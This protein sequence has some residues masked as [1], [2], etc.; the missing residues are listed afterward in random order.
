MQQDVWNSLEIA[1]LAATLLT[2]IVV[3]V[4]GF[5]ISRRLKQL[6][7]SQWRSQKLIEK[8]LSVYDDLVPDL[9]RLLCYFTYVGDW[10]DTDPPDVV[11]LKRKIDRKIYLAAPL[12]S[13]SF[14]KTNSTFLNLCFRTYNEWGRDAS[15]K[16]KFERRRESRLAD[17]KKEWEQ[18]FANE[19][20]PLEEIQEAYGAAVQAIARDIGVHDGFSMPPPAR[21]PRDIR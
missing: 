19:A 16:T 1:K 7:H 9:N 15:L 6:D 20:T 8:R 13:D 17:W 21:N 2:P 18:C 5:F 14:F 10:R 3:A 12:F 4:I 11:A